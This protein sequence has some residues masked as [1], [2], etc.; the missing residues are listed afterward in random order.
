[1][2]GSYRSATPFPSTPVCLCYTGTPEPQR[3]DRRWFGSG[4]GCALRNNFPTMGRL[5]KQPTHCP[6]SRLDARMHAL[7][8][9]RW[10]W[11]RPCGCDSSLLSAL[12]SH[13]QLTYMIN[14]PHHVRH[15]SPPNAPYI[16]SQAPPGSP[17]ASPDSAPPEPHP[18][19]RH[20]R[21]PQGK[22]PD[23]IS[24]ALALLH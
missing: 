6:C 7:K 17:N 10:R 19:R 3:V 22:H 16:S 18:Y 13:L 2:V 23:P 14:V 12:H 8:I 21:R 15:W 9:N 11:R 20:H 4:S 24:P 1:M 5:S